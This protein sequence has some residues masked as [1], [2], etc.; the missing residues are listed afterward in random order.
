[1]LTLANASIYTTA[2]ERFKKNPSAH[3]I[4]PV[5]N[6]LVSQD[7]KDR[8]STPEFT[9]V[10]GVVIADTEN[11]GKGVY[12][13]NTFN[14]GDTVATYAP[15][16]EDFLESPVTRKSIIIVGELAQY[17]AEVLGVD[18]STYALDMMPTERDRFFYFNGISRA[19][20]IIRKKGDS[21]HWGLVGGTVDHPW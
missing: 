5:I 7:Q 17:T 1:M 10:E 18:L 2:Y 15:R 14:T 13:L 4:Q 12:A 8:L 16:L 6:V 21:N 3:N 20:Q 9:V 11:K 19:T